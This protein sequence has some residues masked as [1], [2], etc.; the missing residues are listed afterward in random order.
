MKADKF[1]P[2]FDNILV[3]PPDVV[4]V[5]PGGIYLP[6]SVKDRQVSTE[7]IVIAVG[8]DCEVVVEGDEVMYGQYV[9]VDITLNDKKYSIIKEG[10][11]LGILKNDEEEKDE[12]IHE[13]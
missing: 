6:D 8:P 2:L 10:D 9:G 4:D 11:L 1:M 3:K 13:S 12:D 5:S 7:G